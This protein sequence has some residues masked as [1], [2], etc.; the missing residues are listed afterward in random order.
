MWWQFGIFSII[1]SVLDFS[2][3]LIL[4]TL[5][6][7]SNFDWTWS[8]VF[9]PL[10]IWLSVFLVVDAFLLYLVSREKNY[11]YSNET[12][13][14]ILWYMSSGFGLLLWTIFIALK[15]DDVSTFGNAY[16]YQVFI[17]L[18]LTLAMWIR[19]MIE[20]QETSY[21]SYRES[22]LNINGRERAMFVNLWSTLHLYA[23]FTVFLVLYLDGVV[24]WSWATI[25]SPIWVGYGL[26]FFYYISFL[27]MLGKADSRTIR[28][29]FWLTVIVVATISWP[30]TICLY[31][32]GIISM[33]VYALIPYWIA[34]CLMPLSPF[35]LCIIYCCC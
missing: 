12:L 32:S 28:F 10:W 33:L 30:I 7:D 14:W 13:G 20:L 26:Y 6:V 18:W 2:I 29:H 3:F 34:L 15:L 1:L 8:I 21:G 27:I 4:L 5:K 16:W 17:P 23:L 11:Y 25:F 24:D 35:L 31:L 19:V 9:I 22:V